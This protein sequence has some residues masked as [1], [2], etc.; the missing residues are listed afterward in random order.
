MNPAVRP[1]Y[2]ARV[3]MAAIGAYQRI[4]AGTTSRCRFAPSCSQYSKDAIEVYGL[5][6]G[7][8]MGIKR[9]GRCHP[10]HPGGYDPVTLPNTR[11]DREGSP[12]W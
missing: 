2:A 6:R 4:M 1:G 8:W 11:S 7:A 10:W 3:G 12:Q 9:I 5:T